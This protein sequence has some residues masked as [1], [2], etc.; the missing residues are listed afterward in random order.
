[1]NTYVTD[2]QMYRMQCKMSFVADVFRSIRLRMEHI[3]YTD[4]CTSL[5]P[6]MVVFDVF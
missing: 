6:A 2:G 3:C 4:F 1:M 5:D